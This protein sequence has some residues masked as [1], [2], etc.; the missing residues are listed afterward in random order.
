MLDLTIPTDIVEVGAGYVSDELLQVRR[1]QRP[2]QEG[3]VRH[4]Q[5]R[6][7]RRRAT[8]ANRRHALAHH[9]HQPRAGH[10][11][12][13]RRIRRA[14]QVPDRTSA[15]T[16]CARTAPTRTR[17]RTSARAPTSSRCPRHWIV[18]RVPQVEQRPRATSAD[19]SP[20][21]GTRQRA[22]G[23]RVDTAHGG[24]DTHGQQHHRGRRAALPERRPSHQAQDL[25][26]RLQLQHQLA[27]GREGER[28]ATRTR[29]ATSR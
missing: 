10:A 29:M 15:T 20:T 16:S 4:R 1:V 5:L 7:A 22:R 3:P 9:G 8:E 19:S 24:A 17:R 18:P 23:R 26:R 21:A 6:P 2:V 27:L 28:A 12:R 25:R 13:H 11:Q 14:G